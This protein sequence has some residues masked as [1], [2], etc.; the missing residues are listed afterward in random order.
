MN[1]RLDEI[2][3][4]LSLSDEDTMV[5][6]MRGKAFQNWLVTKLVSSRPGDID[7]LSVRGNFPQLWKL[8]SLETNSLDHSGDTSGMELKEAVAVCPSKIRHKECY[9]KCIADWTDICQLHA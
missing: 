4:W 5:W 1:K 8:S 7:K 6:K 2:Q 9:S 3:R